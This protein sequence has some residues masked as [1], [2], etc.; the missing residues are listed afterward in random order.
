MKYRLFRTAPFVALAL[1]GGPALNAVELP[2]TASAI[3]FAEAGFNNVVDFNLVEMPLAEALLQFI[4]T[5][6][7][8]LVFDSRLVVN[9]KAPKVVGPYA[10]RIALDML[11][12]D[13][14]LNVINV[15]GDTFAIVLKPE[16]H[17][18]KADGDL[19]EDM[20]L[21][22]TDM[23]F[24]SVAVMDE[25][26]VVGT[27]TANPPYYKF[28]PTASISGEKLRFSGTVNV[29]DYLFQLPSML[30]DVT[31][32]NTTIFGTPAGLN[33]ADLRGLGAE[34]TLVMIN[35]RRIIPTY[36]G[37]LNLYGVDLNSIPSALV[38]Q[39]DVISGGAATTFGGEA[40]AG[41]VNFTLQDE[42]EGWS[43]GVQGGITEK[44]DRKE[45]MGTLMYG[46]KFADDKGSFV[47]TLTLDDQ[48]GLYA[49][50]RDITSNPSGFAVD[51]RRASPYD[52][53]A[54]LV[55]GFGGST[56]TP[57]GLL[58]G[59]VTTQGE[60]SWLPE[61]Q[62]FSEDGTSLAPHVGSID[63][64][65]N[66]A[67][68]ITLLTPLERMF[69]TMSGK[70]EL[71]DSHKLFFE[72]SYNDTDV[73]SQLA[74]IPV[75]MVSGAGNDSGKLIYVPLSNPYVP[76]A[77]LDAFDAAGIRDAAGLFIAKRFMEIGP[78]RTYISRR[79]LRAM[80]G[81]QGMLMPEWSYDLYYQ[82]GWNGVE[83][84]R[85]GLMD[86]INYRTA[87]DPAS[88][89]EV[90]GC[91]VINPFGSGNI[92]PEQAEFL[93]APNAIRKVRAN[94]H[95]AS[96]VV[97]GPV[98][99]SEDLD[100]KV[101][102]G[103]EYRKESLSDLPDPLLETR[104]VSGS[105]LYPGST[106]EFDV[107]EVFAD[108]TL[109][110]IADE[111]WAEELTATLGMRVSDFST[112]GTNVNWHAGGVWS[113]V[114]S[115]S[116]RVSYQHGHR[117]PNIAELYSAGPGGYQN[118]QDPCS[119]L[120]RDGTEIMAANCYSP[121]RLS[122]QDG[123][124]QGEFLVRVQ[125]YGNPHLDAEKSSNFTWGATYETTDIIGDVPGRLKV[126]V[127]AYR[128]KVS[129]FIVEMGAYDLLDACYGSE[130]L[131]SIF[132]GINPVNGEPYIQRNP[133]SGD[134][135]MITSTLI[136]AG[137]AWFKGYDV[138]L[139]YVVDLSATSNK[140]LLDQI[141]FSTLYTRNLEV[142]WQQSPEGKMES[143]LGQA[144][145]PKHRLQGGISLTKGSV[146]VDWDV[147]F[148]SKS[149]SKNT[150]A[151]LPEAAIDAVWYHDIG[152]RLIL[153]GGTTLYG[154][155]RNLFDRSA[156]RTYGGSIDDT[157]PEFFD[158]L[159]RR[160]YVGM[161]FDF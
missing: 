50:E 83:E 44:G 16:A 133:A 132:C 134:L 4:D 67:P 40:V 20:S 61:L 151:D 160:F 144:K 1:S 72:A 106:G 145:Y 21:L 42:I 54:V 88:C 63:Q 112:T 10:A 81:L 114:N 155:V 116:F 156:P 43:G 129:D 136:N 89:A 108:L 115:L 105:L 33:L 104:P 158:T 71:G 45:L 159:G 70:Y 62:V 38:K 41:V 92:T 147:R 48:D 139:Q 146:T 79:T 143:R 3:G 127:D 76:Q 7:L 152:A 59:A 60:L 57:Q 52:E 13:S 122:V 148:R 17:G 118:Y 74:P 14:G 80:I 49:G 36:G 103:L 101:S 25:L 86:I 12:A 46:T 94:Q 39:I 109:P 161:V 97:S 53:G 30:S 98:A 82:Y 154:G 120:G 110:L 111:S 84:E 77:A 29:A 96:A 5:T 131:Q 18:K 125:S 102:L 126:S 99:L 95:I 27:R 28:K 32:A 138:A 58:Y 119:R 150:L 6:G 87:L 157:F 93:T 149:V 123:F 47:A 35:G 75:T 56:I 91:S 153:D 51:G 55:P 15:G 135:E 23:A 128:I 9:K 64:I 117:A 90:A 66:Y 85:D 141:S 69:A 65:Y 107:A 100:G 137:N 31:A 68:E 37:S 78:R 113:P 121:S 22:S 73:I 19:V 140:T 11:L 26:L 142:M 124:A 130:N 24:S 8:G 2:A 34:R